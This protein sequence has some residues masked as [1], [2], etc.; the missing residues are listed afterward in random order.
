MTEPI[1]VYTTC[2]SSH[3]V[4]AGAYR[5]RAAEVARWTESHGCRGLLV[6][7]DNTLIDPWS[8]AQHLLAET[9]SLVPM[10]AVQPVYMH[11]YTV[12]RMIS[13][14]AF[15]HGRRVDLNLVTGGFQGHLAALG[16][17]LGHDARYDR[18]VEYAGLL[19]RLLEQDRPVSHD[20][21]HYR[22]ARASVE[23]AL[24][25]GL[26]PR[27]FV[28]GSS[29][30]CRA[31]QETLG[32][33]RL[34]YPQWLEAPDWDP[35][36]LSGGMR[37][38][39]IARDTAEEAWRVA[40][41]RFPPD[42]SGARLHQVAARMVESQWHRTLSAAGT[43]RG[44]PYWQHPFRTYRTFCPYLVGSHSE[45]GEILGRY[46]E[47]GVRTVILDVPVEEA[48]LVH[49][50]IAFEHS[51]GFHWGEGPDRRA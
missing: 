12:A 42:P 28:S 34:S 13:S 31:A 22:L 33:T 25:P 3:G 18:L 2:P 16:D 47:T 40:H 21:P 35:E 30:A 36:H 7:T 38:G 19:R 41:E 44:L 49:T 43:V 1:T 8:A 24:P 26:R 37:V 50:R 10:V 45:V 11:P 29:E 39:V 15:L 27:I 23:P 14:L 17:E 4:E 5:R 9:G 51:R 20:G 32:A 46:F 6:Y 48:D